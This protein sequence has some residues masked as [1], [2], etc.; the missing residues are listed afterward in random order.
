MGPG[1][2]EPVLGDIEVLH[3]REGKRVPPQQAGR[4]TA[5]DTA[6]LCALASAANRS[7]ASRAK[8]LPP[9]ARTSSYLG[10]ASVPTHRRNS[11]VEATAKFHLPLE[12]IDAQA[13]R[14]LLSY[15]GVPLNVTDAAVAAKITELS[16]LSINSNHTRKPAEPLTWHRLAAIDA[17]FTQLA[18]LTALR[19]G[20]PLERSA[21]LFDPEREAPQQH[22]G[23]E[24]GRDGYKT[25]LGIAR[26]ACW[27]EDGRAQAAPTV[28]SG[29]RPAMTRSGDDDT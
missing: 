25:S 12:H 8:T 7:G 19:H 18:Q 11:F 9:H 5:A 1:S 14:A 26:W 29:P 17:E 23:W 27:V 3:R 22:C 21:L 24:S 2:I 13:I 16:S 20:F 28:R 10:E 15:A 4:L 6:A